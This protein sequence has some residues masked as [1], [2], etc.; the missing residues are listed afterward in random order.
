MLQ[1]MP[2]EMAKKKAG[3]PKG[4]AKTVDKNKPIIATL[5][6][7]DEFRE[8]LEEVAKK[9]HRSVASLIERAIVS[10]AKEVGVTREPPE[11]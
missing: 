10:Y 5:R 1:T 2:Q 11:R 8:F 4:S 9:D 6:G 3:R 7:S